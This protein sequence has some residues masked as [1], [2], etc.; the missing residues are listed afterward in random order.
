M[1]RGIETAAS[2]MIALQRKQDT[3][4]NNLAN[5]ETPGYKQDTSP[6][7]AFPELLLARIHDQTSPATGKAPI[8]GP[9][10]MG[11]YNQETLPMFTQG[12]L[13]STNSPYDVAI[14]DQQLAPVMQNNR[15]VKPAVMFA[16]QTGDGEFKLTRN[17]QFAVNGTGQLTTSSGDL[18]LGRNG[19]PIADADL[20][21][22]NVLIRENG[23]IIVHPDDPARARTIGSLGGV[24]VNDPNQLVKEG[25]GLY[26]LAGATTEM[27]VDTVPAGVSL[28]QKTLEQSNVEMSQT[29]SEMM[30]NIRLYEANQ[31][32]LHAY[33][34]T[35][36]QLNTIG[37][38]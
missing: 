37:R 9:L 10:S 1:L 21:S 34:K 30:A 38:V 23:E 25:N 22:G 26:Q 7:R 5:I 15:L 28:H 24:L 19:T 16:V 32:V 3:L 8:V 27:I 13:V 4:T 35:L 33:D 31:K 36:E 20:T 2:G 17:G 14:N 29:I 6:L 18:V 11:V 12:S